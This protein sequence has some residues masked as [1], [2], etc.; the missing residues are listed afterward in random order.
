LLGAVVGQGPDKGK[1]T[2]TWTAHDK[3]MARDPITLSYA[4]KADGDWKRFA[5]KLPNDGRYVWKMP[6]A[7]LP[8]QFHV[9][10]EAIDL[11]GNVGEAITTDLV[12]VDLSTPKVRI[13]NVEPAWK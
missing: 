12:K 11:A 3:N 10:V 7:D 5:E 9:K 13:L 6:T 2:I 4:D 1:L 8:Y